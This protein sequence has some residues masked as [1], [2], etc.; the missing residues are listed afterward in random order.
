MPFPY[1]YYQTYY[2]GPVNA[3]SLKAKALYLTPSI[4]DVTTGGSVDVAGKSHVV[5]DARAG[6]FQI[7][8][9]TGSIDGQV[10]FIYKGYSANTVTIKHNLDVGNHEIFMPNAQDLV[11][12][13]NNFGGATFICKD[14]GGVMEWYQV[15]SNGLFGNGSAITP[16]ISFASDSDT[17]L[18]N[19]AANQIGLSTSGVLR[20]LVT[21]TYI[22]STV[23]FRTSDGSAALPA[24]TFESDPD[25][26]FF[27]TATAIA[28][29]AD[30]V[31]K[32]EFLKTGAIGMLFPNFISETPFEFRKAT[33]PQAVRAG[34]L[35]ISD[36]FA[37]ASLVPVNGIYSKGNVKTAG[38][39]E[40][41]AT[42]AKFADLAERYK[43]DKE[44]SAGTLVSIGGLEEITETMGFG[45]TEVFGIISNKPAF[46][47][48]NNVPDGQDEKLW[49]YV[50][51]AGRVPCRVIG[52]IKKGE[53]I[54]PSSKPGFGQGLSS[55]MIA[56]SATDLPYLIVGRSLDTKETDGEGI[57]EVAIGG[58]K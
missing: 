48:N 46:A 47:M 21:T 30:A 19:P 49:P 2:N 41:T 38:L 39:F 20:M 4:P 27:K 37:D 28:F 17:G 1:A 35:L 40:G 29:S 24:W 5:L 14:N 13:A 53:R 6:S 56:I 50:A 43:A 11:L 54:I 18:Y 51:L 55:A 32:I 16:S 58:L 36:N 57:V 12:G 34:T 10:L 33:G 52:K 9:F 44:Y 26:G 22:T 8:S 42:S 25:T 15:D 3:L 31:Q 7:D 23:P 45:D